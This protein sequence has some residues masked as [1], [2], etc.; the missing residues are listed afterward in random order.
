MTTNQRRKLRPPPEPTRPAPLDVDQLVEL[1]YR[2]LR[3]GLAARVYGHPPK[4]RRG[5]SGGTA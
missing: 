3:H 1:E 5:R 4:H 2:P